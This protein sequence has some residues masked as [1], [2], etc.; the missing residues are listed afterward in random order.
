MKDIKDLKILLIGCGKIAD[1]HAKHLKAA[2][3]H[4]SFYARRF[5]Q[6]QE[7]ARK[8]GGN[9]YSGELVTVLNARHFDG[10]WI[11]T[12]P[13]THLEILQICLS[14]NLKCFCEKPLVA[15]PAH[16]SQ[17]SALPR[18]AELV[19]VGEN[20]LYRPMLR[21]LDQVL[22]THDLGS[23]SDIKVRKESFQ[24]VRGW[25][26][27]ESALIEG[28]IHFVALI[29]EILGYPIFKKIHISEKDSQK[30]FQVSAQTQT[31]QTVELRYSWT[32]R[33]SLPAGLLQMSTINFERAILKFESNGLFA[34]LYDVDG[35]H[36]ESRYF[37]RDLGGFRAM[38]GDALEWIRGAQ[39]QPRSDY[40]KAVAA[41]RFAF[42]HC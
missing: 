25:R 9:A 2:G 4:L 8:F 40:T 5:E 15:T 1:S 32:N 35:V 3:V 34:K 31:H 14:K 19:M 6:A 12:P 13:D 30:S 33:W 20:Y 27:S 18:A 29:L 39:A 38:T 36:L 42:G 23:I 21:W 41:L 22:A 26:Q 28:G 10:V 24:K 16:L 17:L 37:G 11:C 7:F